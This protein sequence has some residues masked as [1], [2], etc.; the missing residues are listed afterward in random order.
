MPLGIA[1]VVAGLLAVAVIVWQPWERYGST[2]WEADTHLI[3]EEARL[4]YIVPEGWDR[5]SDSELEESVAASGFEVPSSGMSSSEDK[6]FAQVQVQPLDAYWGGGEIEGDYDPDEELRVMAELVT[7]S[8]QAM[9]EGH[10][11]IESESLTIDGFEA[12]TATADAPSPFNEFSD[13]PSSILWVRAT[14]VDFGDDQRSVLYSMALIPESEL[15]AESGVIA[16]LNTV[17]D[18]IEV[19]D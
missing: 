11:S 1:A 10:D 5:M 13:G 18:S 6:V 9:F 14:V 17:H 8:S 3:D 12:A 15:E 2:C 19:P 16:D 7:V 4:C